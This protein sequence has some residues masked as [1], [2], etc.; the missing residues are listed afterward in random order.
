LGIF[1]ICD[2][3]S[4][5]EN[6]QE[7]GDMNGEEGEEYAELANEGELRWIAHLLD[8]DFGHLKNIFTHNSQGNFYFCKF[9]N[10][11]NFI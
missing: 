9:K 1:A 6:G 2:F 11:I 4:S 7:N 10:K 5:V 8:V 3:Q